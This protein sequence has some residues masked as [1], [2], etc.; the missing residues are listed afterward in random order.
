LS[1]I[2]NMAALISDFSTR[3]GGPKNPQRAS[4]SEIKS[5]VNGGNISGG[6]KWCTHHDI[7]QSVGGTTHTDPDPNYPFDL[8]QQALDAFAAPPK[9]PTP[10]TPAPTTL[11]EWI[12]TLPGAPA[13]L[14]YQQFLADVANAVLGQ[15][16]PIDYVDAYLM[17]TN[18][19]D[20]V[21]A[22][23]TGHLRDFLEV[24][25]NQDSATFRD[26]HP[27]TKPSKS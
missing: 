10:P 11:L 14:T 7:T 15:G 8:L 2:K 18:G 13:N 9:P 1:Q 23:R 16:D 25:G 4:Q 5:Y 24:R 22:T 20:R 21:K 27:A 6:V 17:A 19:G 12:M 3:H 26:V